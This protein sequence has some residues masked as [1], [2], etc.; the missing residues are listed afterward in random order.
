MCDR[1]CAQVTQ[2]GTGCTRAS[3]CVLRA[4]ASVF[5]GDWV[6]VGMS[7]P[8]ALTGAHMHTPSTQP[9]LGP[10]HGETPWVF[11]MGAPS[12]RHCWCP[13]NPLP[14]CVENS[15]EAGGA[16]EGGKL[17]GGRGL[18]PCWQVCPPS[19]QPSGNGDTKAGDGPPSPKSA[20]SGAC[21]GLQQEASLYTW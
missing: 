14:P 11:F 2:F 8:A 21:S 10:G 3:L 1:L 13:A 9:F 6:Q 15:L 20:R 4:S 12:L 16:G 5:P 7:D 18:R 19:P 17:G